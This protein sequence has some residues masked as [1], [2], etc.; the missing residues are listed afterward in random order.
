MVFFVTVRLA[1]YLSMQEED[2][3]VPLFPKPLFLRLFFSVAILSEV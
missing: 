2:R 1:Q 3:I